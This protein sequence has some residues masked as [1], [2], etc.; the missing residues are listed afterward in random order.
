MSALK[1]KVIWIRLLGKNYMQYFWFIHEYHTVQMGMKIP[2]ETTKQK[3]K[4]L[5][6]INFGIYV[7]HLPYPNHLFKTQLG[8][9]F[10]VTYSSTI[11]LYWAKAAQKSY[12]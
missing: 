5:P 10:K 9:E 6:T 1:P 4:R 12:S 8:K 3:S 7:F 2:H 11:Y